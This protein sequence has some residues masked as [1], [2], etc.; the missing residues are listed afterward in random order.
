MRE[1][2]F[3]DTSEPD[4]VHI[5]H[6]EI[7]RRGVEMSCK[8]WFETANL[9]WVVDAIR[10]RLTNRALPETGIDSGNDSLRVFETS[11]DDLSSIA[12]V[13]DR[14]DDAPYGG[15]HTQILSKSLAEELVD[16]LAD[17]AQD[18]I[19]APPRRIWWAEEPV[20][21]LYTVDV[22]NPDFVHIRYVQHPFQGVRIHE[23]MY[24]QEAVKLRH[25]EY[26]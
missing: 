3:I 21:E 19:S 13:N 8:V 10:A 15:P 6:V 24:L 20:Q 7:G 18:V 5:D 9:P 16:D 23:L 2:Y 11:F 14:T 26:S 4:F 1:S 12:I 22:S 17:I 25:A